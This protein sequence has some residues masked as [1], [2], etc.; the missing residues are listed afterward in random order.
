MTKE[1]DWGNISNDDS[2]GGGNRG[3]RRPKVEWLKV[4]KNGSTRI[5]IVSDKPVEY[6]KWWEPVSGYSCGFDT[7][8]VIAAGY[9]PTR[10][11]GMYVIDSNDNAIK[12]YSCS[13]KIAMALVKWA[14]R[15]GCSPGDAERGVEW[16]ISK[17]RV[18]NKW[19][20]TAQPDD[21]R[22]LTEEERERVAKVLEEAPLTKVFEPDT[23]E[24]LQQLLDEYNANPDGPIPGS[25]DWYQSKKNSNQSSDG[26]SGIKFDENENASDIVDKDDVDGDDAGE[27]KGEDKFDTLFSG[28]EQEEEEG[29]TLF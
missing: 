6:R 1:V 10:S 8:P 14:E 22:P 25:W 2:N 24:R 12:V 16:V 17:D 15:K 29:T 20:Y 9:K 4:P 5:R 18:D 21:Q 13:K 3:P 23:P 19:S 7:D 26:G 11:Y 28:D 27:A